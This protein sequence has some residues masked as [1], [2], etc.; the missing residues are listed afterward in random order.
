MF[1][2]SISCRKQ[3]SDD[4]ITKSQLRE[5]VQQAQTVQSL[6]EEQLA[7][8]FNKKEPEFKEKVV[9]LIFEALN[10]DII[11][12]ILEKPKA[13]EV[14]KQFL[15]KEETLLKAIKAM[16]EEELKKLIT[17]PDVQAILGKYL[18]KPSSVQLEKILAGLTEEEIKQLTKLP[19]V[20]EILQSTMK[21][22]EVRNQ[23]I[24]NLTHEEIKQAL[25]LPTV[26]SA[27][28]DEIT[29]MIRMNN[30]N[31]QILIEQGKVLFDELQIS[32]NR[33]MGVAN[34]LKPN[35]SNLYLKF[36]LSTKKKK[37]D[38]EQ[39]DKLDSYWKDLITL[40]GQKEK[41][42][43]LGVKFFENMIKS[44]MAYER[45]KKS[46]DNCKSP[47]MEPVEVLC[48]NNFK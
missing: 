2:F 23:V 31:A 36:E 4:Q 20:Q 38:C 18:P 21:D 30:E 39:I 8:E 47:Y 12:K 22:P 41:L 3:V 37:Y 32:F 14:I 24:S 46:M 13:Q 34:V 33:K 7:T 43:G 17:H 40:L 27:I 35:T 15:A 28:N 48:K 26:Q 16:N 29:K 6:S 25:Q 44:C 10:N 1:L 42:L 5:R 45:L 9:S 19:K 11:Q